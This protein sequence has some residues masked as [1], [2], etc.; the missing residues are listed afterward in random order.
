MFEQHN[1]MSSA[2]E[3][4]E[5][6]LPM[7]DQEIENCMQLQMELM[8]LRKAKIISHKT[9]QKLLKAAFPSCLSSDEENDSDE[10]DEILAIQRLQSENEDLRKSVRALENLVAGLEPQV[11]FFQEEFRRLSLMTDANS[12]KTIMPNKLLPL[13][14]FFSSSLLYA[15]LLQIL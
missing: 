5:K 4:G 15:L 12:K 6:R 9:G 2:E 14:C 1:L 7:K 3:S 8:K 11:L 10:Y 13:L